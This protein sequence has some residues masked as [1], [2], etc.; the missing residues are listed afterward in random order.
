VALIHLANYSFK[1]F[2]SK[3]PKKVQLGTT[4]AY[5]LGGEKSIFQQFGSISQSNF[6]ILI[7]YVFGCLSVAWGT[8][9][10]FIY[11]LLFLFNALLIVV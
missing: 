9:M 5:I 2:A 7:F 4:G 3:Y 10:H 11:L 6:L 1:P 8:A